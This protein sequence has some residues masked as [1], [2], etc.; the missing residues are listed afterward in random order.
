MHVMLYYTAV[1]YFTCYDWRKI[2]DEEIIIIQTNKIMINIFYKRK[3]THY[4][5]KCV[6]G[7]RY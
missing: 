1:F 5:K 2:I 3:K 6:P 4:I 7:M